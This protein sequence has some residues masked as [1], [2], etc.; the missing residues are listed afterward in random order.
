MRRGGSYSFTNSIRSAPDTRLLG[1]CDGHITLED[2]CDDRT[3]LPP[4]ASGPLLP[5]ALQ[6]ASTETP[7]VVAGDLPSRKL[8]GN[9]LSG[10]Q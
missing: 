7:P 10:P 2:H 9:L 3:A 6:F 4:L 8:A 1:F 5:L